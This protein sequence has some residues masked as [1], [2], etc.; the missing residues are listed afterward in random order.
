MLKVFILAN[1]QD[2]DNIKVR[3]LVAELMYAGVLNP[4]GKEFN[5]FL[6][7]LA[8]YHNTDEQD[9]YIYSGRSKKEVFDGFH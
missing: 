5:V 1:K 7:N 9:F 8:R 2:D 3:L 6:R 4:D